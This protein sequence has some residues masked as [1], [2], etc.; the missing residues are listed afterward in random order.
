MTPYWLRQAV[1]LGIGIAWGC[2][3][4]TGWM[5]LLG[6]AVVMEVTVMM[7]KNATRE[8]DED[9]LEEDEAATPSSQFDGFMPALGVFLCAWIFCYNM[10]LDY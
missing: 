9:E 6:F 7:Y 8:D 10:S 5:G 4:L 1:A 2:V 3:Q